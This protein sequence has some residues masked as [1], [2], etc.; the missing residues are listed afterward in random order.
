LTWFTS[1]KVVY[2][3]PACVVGGTYHC[4]ICCLCVADKRPVCCLVV[5]DFYP[6]RYLCIV[7]HIDVLGNGNLERGLDGWH[8][9]KGDV[10]SDVLQEC[11][12]DSLGILN[13]KV[14]CNVKEEDAEDGD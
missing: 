13:A 14:L 1:L 6:A 10:F 7:C 5:D 4:P 11:S 9:R 12:G 8:I 3:C 2:I